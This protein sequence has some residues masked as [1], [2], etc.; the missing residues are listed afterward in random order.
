M[1]IINNKET[2]QKGS[3]IIIALVVI[4]LVIFVLNHYGITFN[5]VW[6]AI[7]NFFGI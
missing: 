6:Y 4:V 7:K 3:S 5:S 2:L 1:R